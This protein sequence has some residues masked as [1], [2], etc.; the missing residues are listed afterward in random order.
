MTAIAF[1]HGLD[2][3]LFARVVRG[4][5]MHLGHMTF[6]RFPDGESYVR[7]ESECHDQTTLLCIDLSRPD[8]K[9]PGLIF[10]AN[11]LRD[12]GSSSVGLV[13]PYLPYMRQDAIFK[14]GEGLAA[15][16]FAK[17]LSEYFDW[18]VT[19]DPHLHRIDDLGD[20]FDIPAT[21]VHASSPIA[22]WISRNVDEPFF[23]VGPDAESEQWVADVAAQVG[24]EYVVLAKVR[25]GDRDV[26]VSV[27]D[28]FEV[29]GAVPVLI[30]DIVS[31]GHTMTECAAS[32]ASDGVSRPVCI[33][34]HALLDDASLSRFSD[35]GIKQFVSCNSVAHSTNGIDLSGVLIRAIRHRLRQT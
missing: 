21:V 16:Y 27:P 26:C 2:D 8:A 7:I 10:A 1:N 6:R 18:I 28:G 32:F 24:A 4:A 14:Q 25:K 34:V 9:L 33:A 17:L 11:I 22:E 35:A 5:D 30:D 29:G 23:L 3:E 19:V 20:V 15:R 13:A 31:S 12:I